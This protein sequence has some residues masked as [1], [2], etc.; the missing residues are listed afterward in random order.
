MNEASALS[1]ED[2]E[3]ENR[4]INWALFDCRARKVFDMCITGIEKGAIGSA[5]LM[6]PSEDGAL[7]ALLSSHIEYEAV[8]FVLG[9]EQNLYRETK[10]VAFGMG[11]VDLVI[12]ENVLEHL[13]GVDRFFCTIAEIRPREVIVT[14]TPD[15]WVPEKMGNTNSCQRGRGVV[16][17]FDAA[18]RAGY[19]LIR[20]EEILP[21]KASPVCIIYKFEYAKPA[22]LAEFELCTGCATCAAICPADALEMLFDEDGFKR[23]VLDGSRCTDCGLCLNRCPSLNLRF[24]NEPETT[25]Y[26]LKADDDVRACS[27]SGGAFTLLASHTLRSEG[28]GYVCGAFFNRETL[29]VEHTI[30]SSMDEIAPLR[31]SKYVQSDIEDILPKV[32]CI[33]EEDNKP[34]LFVGCPCQVAALNSFLNKSYGQ[35]YTVDF[36]CGGVPSP[37]AFEKYLRETCDLDAIDN[38]SCRPKTYGWDSFWLEITNRDGSVEHR[39]IK[40]DP[41][42]QMFHSLMSGRKSCFTCVFSTSP[43]QGDMTIGDYWG[44]QNFDPSFDDRKGTS[45]ITINNHKGEYLFRKIGSL[46]DCIHEVPK[47]YAA[48]NRVSPK[49]ARRVRI[50]QIRDRF[51]A[52][53]KTLSFS[54]AVDRSINEKYDVAVVSNWGGYNYG[55][56]LTQYSIYRVLSD[57]GYDS[58]MIERPEMDFVGGNCS[59][60]FLFKENPYPSFALCERYETLEDMRD[61]NRY[62]DTFIVPSD[63]LWSSVFAE[64]DL[65]ALGYVNNDKTKISYATSFGHF[66]HNW[67]KADRAREAFFLKQFDALSVRERSGVRILRESFGLEATQVLDPVFLCGKEVFDALAEKSVYRCDCGF[68]FSFVLDPSR[69]KQ[70]IVESLCND[71]KL[72]NKGMTDVMRGEQDRREWSL[73]LL[74]NATIEDLLACIRQSEF[75]ITDSYHGVCFSLI[76]NK[77]F[78]AIANS[79]RGKTRFVSV[80]EQFGLEDRLIDIE[81][82]EPISLS[83][84]LELDYSTVNDLVAEKAKQSLLWLKEKLEQKREKDL[85]GFDVCSINIDAVRK[86]TIEVSEQFKALETRLNNSDEQI[87]RAHEIANEAHFRINNSDEQIWKAHEI[88]NEAHARLD[89]QEEALAHASEAIA[90]LAKEAKELEKIIKQIKESKSFRI[91]RAVTYIPRRIKKAIKGIYK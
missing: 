76:F 3:N 61:I 13:D 66:P 68:V 44:V 79:E 71:M 5:I 77:P 1:H 15:E 47:E 50:P 28:G 55:A 75:V 54:E 90:V 6:S 16:D 81:A 78:V 72:G 30:V 27:S 11:M 59:T 64:K 57:L 12:A 24:D 62:A 10:Q 89:A 19:L 37:K 42:E 4:F 88:A 51:F 60:P 35:L 56:Q 31:Q 67:A 41:Y 26:A 38:V 48:T 46:A 21:A 70:T 18:A 53:N 91:G 14:F 86:S 23:P 63:Q 40:D 83:F 29:R 43:R 17:F 82:E 32:R 25:T 36:L 22:A 80:L 49:L 65:F 39:S 7:G 9:E 85:T 74:E 84:P 33:L 52:L 58:I 87:W 20:S 8:N 34:V 45:Y 69:R 2:G 73:P